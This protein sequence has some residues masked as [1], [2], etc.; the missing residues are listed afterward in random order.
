MDSDPK[1]AIIT[2]G[3][4]GIGRA[5]ALRFVEENIRVVIGDIS[6]ENGKK[7][8]A[9]IESQG[10]EARF[11][12]GNIK[13]DSVC[14]SL[15]ETALN[16]WGRIDI[17]VA[18]AAARSFTSF[19]ETDAEEWESMLGVNMIGTAQTCNAVL[20]TMI[21]QQSGAI[22]LV[23]SVGFIV[24][25]TDMP[26][27]DASKAAIVSMTRTLAIEYGTRNIRVNAVCPGFTVT[28]FHISK[29]KEEGE[30]VTELK[31]AK[32]GALNRPADPSEIASAIYFL[33]SDDASYI[34]GHALVVDGGASAGRSGGARLLENAEADSLPK[35]NAQ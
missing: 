33:V 5:C 12:P 7:T 17:L 34:T 27:Y 9:L 2:G 28:D 25:R 23:S 31:A 16:G 6:E 32:V 3:A 29:A 20:P 19:I 15:A 4:A 8:C 24:G 18:N 30:S 21:A 22:A 14:R 10:G 35:P 11:V 1:V 26:I 13:D